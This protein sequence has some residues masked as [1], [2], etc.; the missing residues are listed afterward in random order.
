MTDYFNCSN[1]LEGNR[2]DLASLLDSSQVNQPYVQL[3]IFPFSKLP[4]K[5]L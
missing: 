2:D 5:T 4:D 1:P 3:L